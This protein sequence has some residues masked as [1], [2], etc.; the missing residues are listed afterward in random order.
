MCIRDRSK[1]EELPSLSVT[2][3]GHGWRI[4]AEDLKALAEARTLALAKEEEMGPDGFPGQAP[5]DKAVAAGT[6]LQTNLM[7]LLA[8][9]LDVEYP[10]RE[11]FD[12]ALTSRQRLVCLK[13]AV[14]S[15]KSLGQPLEPGA[16]GRESPL[17]L[18]APAPA[19]AKVADAGAPPGAMA[20][21]PGSTVTDAD[22]KMLTTEQT[23]EAVLPEQQRRELLRLAARTHE[24]AAVSYTHLTLPT[25]DLV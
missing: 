19:G 8:P 24:L 25:S 5:S 15:A 9:M 7:A 22:D 17:G 3:Q 16:C 14:D 18:R 21:K 6:L 23:L 2:P 12:A 1:T 4:T 13:L 20:P 11:T 10:T